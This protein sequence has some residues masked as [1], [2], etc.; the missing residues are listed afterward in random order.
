MT[1]NR[2]KK[3]SLLFY[4]YF[5]KTQYLLNNLPGILFS[6]SQTLMLPSKS[7]VAGLRS[8]NCV[9]PNVIHLKGCLLRS[10]VAVNKKIQICY[11]TNSNL[12]FKSQLFSQ[13][14]LLNAYLIALAFLFHWLYTHSIYHVLW[15]GFQP[16]QILLSTVPNGSQIELGLRIFPW[17]YKY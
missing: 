17:L 4:A 1:I 9:A 16:L 3:V 8:D 12:I 5:I 10:M 15:Y 11:L 2:C 6:M 13:K 14:Y 7:P